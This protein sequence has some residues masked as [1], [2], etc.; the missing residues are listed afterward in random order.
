MQNRRNYV[1]I[2]SLLHQAI[3]IC[4][5]FFNQLTFLSVYMNLIY[6]AYL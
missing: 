4:V 3:D 5:F 1:A 2:A 6:G